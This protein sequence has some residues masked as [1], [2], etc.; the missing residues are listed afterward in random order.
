M[1]QNKANSVK[2]DGTHNYTLTQY[3]VGSKG[4]EDSAERLEF[5]LVRGSK[6]DG[7]N[8]LPKQDG[9][10]TEQLLW[11]AQNYLS[12]VNVGDMAT[13]E[14]S[15]GMTRC[16]TWPAVAHLSGVG[17]YGLEVGNRSSSACNTTLSAIPDAFPLSWS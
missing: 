4:L 6:V 12:A 9:F 11:I 8:V 13:P 2:A 5:T 1:K 7:E 10:L 3:T 17:P 16:P 15:A 14:T